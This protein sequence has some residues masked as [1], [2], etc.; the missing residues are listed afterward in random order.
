MVPIPAHGLLG[1][2][3]EVLFAGVAVIFL[4]MMIISWLYSR[5]LAPVEDDD[6]DENAPAVDAA[7]EPPADSD[8][9][10]ELK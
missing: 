10:F 4:V 5:N 8:R 2:L 1:A 9:H 3:D 7:Q 6:T